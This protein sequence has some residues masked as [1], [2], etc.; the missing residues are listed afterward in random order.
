MKDNYELGTSSGLPESPGP[1]NYSRHVSLIDRDQA[2]LMRL[3]KKPV[4]KVSLYSFGSLL[5]NADHFYSVDLGSFL[6][7][8]SAVRSLSPGRAS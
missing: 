8:G 7:W 5:S 6:Y 3:G 1:T 4:L 2:D